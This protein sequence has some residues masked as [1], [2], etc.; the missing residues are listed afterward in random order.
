MRKTDGHVTYITDFLQYFS[1]KGKKVEI[2]AR[3]GSTCPLSTSPSID[4]CNV[5]TSL[6]SGT[7]YL[8][9]LTY[10]RFFPQVSTTL[11]RSWKPSQ[12]WQELIFLF[13]WFEY[14][15]LLQSHWAYSDIHPRSSKFGRLNNGMLFFQNALI[16]EFFHML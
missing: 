6:T 1:L 15:G 4:Q 11:H 8:I 3:G 12:K 2:K 9:L 16:Q 7:W 10:F 13:S 14:E 5:L